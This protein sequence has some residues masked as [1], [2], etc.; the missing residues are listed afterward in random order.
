MYNNYCN[1]T[2]S[3]EDYNAINNHLNAI[4]SIINK[5]NYISHQANTISKL[6]SVLCKVSDA[7]QEML[8]VQV[9]SEHNTQQGM[10]TEDTTILRGGM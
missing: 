1:D 2:I 10:I 7:K 4:S 8:M 3:K 5:Y 9:K 6:H